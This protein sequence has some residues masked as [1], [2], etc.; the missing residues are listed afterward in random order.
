[1]SR[2]VERRHLSQPWKDLSLDLWVYI[3]Y[4]M[5]SESRLKRVA[6]LGC[7]I[8]EAELTRREELER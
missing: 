4:G 2:I 1:M 8:A 5:T 6:A 7:D 3:W